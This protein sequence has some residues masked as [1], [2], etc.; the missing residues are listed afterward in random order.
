M[1]QETKIQQDLI[2]KHL[3]TTSAKINILAPLHS[4]KLRTK[5]QT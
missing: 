1:K 5:P 4:E 2:P 3:L